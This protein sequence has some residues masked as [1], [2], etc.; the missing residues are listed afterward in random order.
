MWFIG[1]IR[2]L[3]PVNSQR[4]LSTPRRT[5]TSRSTT[6]V[7]E[8]RSIILDQM[9]DEMVHCD[10]WE[11]GF[12]L[13]L[14]DVEIAPKDIEAAFTALKDRELLKD[15]KDPKDPDRKFQ[16]TN[17]QTNPANIGTSSDRKRYGPLVKI[18]EV[19]GG[20]Q[21][22]RR[23]ASCELIQ[24]PDSYNT[25]ETPGANFKVDAYLKLRSSTTP[26]SHPTKIPTADLAVPSEYKKNGGEFVSVR[27][28]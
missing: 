26:T 4:P 5:G 25:A 6:N 14:P 18:C 20:L 21:L 12:N 3:T 27:G 8:H 23:E 13:Y 24:A 19:L 7:T 9:K 1:A 28:S 22:G 2:S 10:K 17:F 16:F 11:G 15:I